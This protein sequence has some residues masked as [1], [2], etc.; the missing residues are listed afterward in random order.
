MPSAR[1]QNLHLVAFELAQ[2]A[3]AQ[4]RAR[5]DDGNQLPHQ[6]NLQPCRIRRQEQPLLAALVV[7]QAEQG[8]D[9]D[10]PL[11]VIG[12]QWQVLAKRQ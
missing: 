7:F 11:I 10:T 1:H 9:L 3:F 5:G 12:T 2:Q 6:V 4:R 8:T